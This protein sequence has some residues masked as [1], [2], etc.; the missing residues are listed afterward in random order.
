MQTNIPRPN[1]PVVDLETGLIDREWWRF[2]RDPIFGSVNLESAVG[3]QS[4]GT[5]LTSGIAG[6]VLA[7]TSTTSISSSPL[8][9]AS[10]LVLGG[11]IGQTPSTPVGLGTT[12]TVL[13]GNAIGSPSFASVSLTADVAG[14]LPLT[15]RG[16]GDTA[17]TSRGMVR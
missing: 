8:L 7:F 1:V 12:T 3:V 2:F 17:R 5:G 13:H 14:V 6:G 11:G 9:S 4:G 16:T 15:S 10:A